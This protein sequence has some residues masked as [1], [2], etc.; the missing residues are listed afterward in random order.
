MPE[1][2]IKPPIRK[3]LMVICPSYSE[4]VDRDRVDGVRQIEAEDLRIKVELGVEGAADVFGAP[5]AVLLALGGEI[6]DRD[7]LRPE[8]VDH[9]FGL[10]RRYDFVFEAL[11]EDHGLGE[12]FDVVDGRALDVEVSALGVGTDKTIEIAGLELMG[13]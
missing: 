8:R 4:V 1:L 3:S 10:V 12:A 5:E 6:G 9:C 11:E 2:P 7:A 13:V